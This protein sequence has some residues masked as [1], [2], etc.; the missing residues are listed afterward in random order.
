MTVTMVVVVVALQMGEGATVSKD[1]QRRQLGSCNSSGG[2]G[3]KDELMEDNAAFKYS[4]SEENFY[5]GTINTKR[6]AGIPRP[7]PRSRPYTEYSRKESSNHASLEHIPTHERENITS[8]DYIFPPNSHSNNNNK[9][10]SLFGATNYKQTDN[11]NTDLNKHTGT[12][13]EH[14]TSKKQEYTQTPLEYT[15]KNHEH[16]QTDK[17]HD[18]KKITIAE[19]EDY[20]QTPGDLRNLL[21]IITEGLSSEKPP[22]IPPIYPE[23]SVEGRQHLSDVS[24]SGCHPSCF[25]GKLKSDAADL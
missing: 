22:I 2:C 14:T 7:R 3:L 17:K 13:L 6:A 25:K 5:T 8:T 15:S 19:E 12:S 21:S 1:R 4:G 24:C 18:L 16:T 11:T 20:R 9:F 23:M 10:A